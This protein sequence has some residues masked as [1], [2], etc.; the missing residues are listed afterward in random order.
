MASL[1]GGQE[2]GGRNIKKDNVFLG[3]TMR[4]WGRAQ[5]A[6]GVLAWS[7]HAGSSTMAR[8]GSSL[9]ELFLTGFRTPRVRTAATTF[10]KD[11][12]CYQRKSGRYIISDYPIE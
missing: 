6:V 1:D 10:R 12:S 11:S 4:N 7:I 2:T 9:G 5:F 3:N 8:F